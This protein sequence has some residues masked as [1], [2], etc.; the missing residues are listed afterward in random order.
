MPCL[1]CGWSLSESISSWHGVCIEML[2]AHLVQQSPWGEAELFLNSSNL[3]GRCF[4]P[5]RSPGPPLRRQTS[6]GSLFSLLAGF[7]NHH[8]VSKHNH[9]PWMSS[10]LLLLPEFCLQSQ[11]IPII[12]YT[13]SVWGRVPHT[14][15]HSVCSNIRAWIPRDELR[16]EKPLVS[17]TEPTS[18]M[19]Y[20]WI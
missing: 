16:E 3:P 20:F 6:S 19:Y 5:S 17:L 9:F 7:I 1:L 2:A 12:I 4:P 10:I 13:H 11:S 14:F 15:R 18:S 8:E